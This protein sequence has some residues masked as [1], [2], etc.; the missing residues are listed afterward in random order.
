MLTVDRATADV[1]RD[2]AKN[3]L[4]FNH[5]IFEDFLDFGF[6]A[7]FALD[8]LPR[9]VRGHRHRRLEPRKPRGQRETFEIPM[10]EDL[11]QQ[12]ERRRYDLGLTNI[13]R[14][15][16]IG[17]NNPIPRKPNRAFAVNDAGADR[18]ACP[19]K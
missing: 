7:R 10:T 5:E 17:A 9:S 1:L 8:A 4:V 13:V 19:T 3:M 6:E 16:D 12:L 18:S 2:Q 14:L 15:N 11:A